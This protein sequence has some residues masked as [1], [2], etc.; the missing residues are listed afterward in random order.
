M[1]KILTLIA[2]LL[3]VTAV[4][5][6]VKGLQA[7]FTHTKTA[8]GTTEK[9]S[10]K[11]YYSAPGSLALHYDAPSHSVSFMYWRRPSDLR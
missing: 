4:S 7:S 5:A 9:D 3:C 8:A 2:A 1:K 11:I 6:Q 10:G